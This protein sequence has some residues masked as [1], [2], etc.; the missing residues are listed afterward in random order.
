[1]VGD[2]YIYPLTAGGGGGGSTVTPN[3]TLVGNEPNLV[4][5]EIDGDKFKIDTTTYASFPNTWVTNGTILQFCASVNSDASAVKGSGY[6]GELRCNDLPTG[7]SNVE[8]IV[9]VVDGEGTSGKVIHITITSGN[10]APYRWEYTYWNDGADVSGWISWELKS[11]I[12]T[13]TLNKTYTS[14]DSDYQQLRDDITNA[15]DIRFAHYYFRCTDIINGTVYRYVN[16]YDT[17]NKA[18]ATHIVL[19]TL[20]NSS[21]VISEMEDAIYRRV[22][23]NETL[24]GNEANLNELTVQNTKYAISNFPKCPNDTNGVFTLQATVSNGSVSYQW[25][26]VQG[27]YFYVNPN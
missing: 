16:N 18:F 2:K 9:D 20:N 26:P 5:I 8:A 22:E 17:G 14:S 25:I 13:Y 27:D 11:E 7:L 1:M 10:L 6:L 12:H 19:I 24:S 15:K 23:A 21:V 3:P 4:G